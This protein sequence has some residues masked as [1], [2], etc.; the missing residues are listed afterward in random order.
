MHCLVTF[1]FTHTEAGA[2]APMVSRK[3]VVVKGHCTLHYH[4]VTRGGARE[5][6]DGGGAGHF[7]APILRPRSYRHRLRSPSERTSLY[8]QASE[9]QNRRSAVKGCTLVVTLVAEKLRVPW[10]HQLIR[11]P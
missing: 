3:G 6:S 5:P 1:L 8:K 4:D 2:R 7:V 9:R 11:V 10:N